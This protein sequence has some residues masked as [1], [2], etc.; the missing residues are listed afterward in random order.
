MANP[1][2]PSRDVRWGIN[3]FF[4]LFPAYKVWGGLT[5]IVDRF[6]RY[7]HL[8]SEIM[9]AILELSPRDTFTVTTQVCR[10]DQI[11]YDIYRSTDHWQ[12]LLFYNGIVDVGNL[13]PG[14]Q[15]RYPSLQDL[16]S[17]LLRYLGTKLPFQ[18]IAVENEIEVVY[19]GSTPLHNEDGIRYGSYIKVPGSTSISS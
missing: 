18:S 16:E 10:P 1:V 13:R 7:D 15:L 11:S 9:D 12:I 3:N 5:E 17:V 8:T 6:E 19:G 4:T 2:I 14:V